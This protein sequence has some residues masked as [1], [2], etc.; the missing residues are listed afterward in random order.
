MRSNPLEEY[1]FFEQL[2]GDTVVHLWGNTFSRDQL[3]E[4][5]RIS[6]PNSEVRGRRV[7][8]PGGLTNVTE[9][10]LSWNGGIT[11]LTIPEDM[12]NMTRLDVRENPL[13]TLSLPVW[14][15]LNNLQI[16]GFPEDRVTFHAGTLKILNEDLSWREGV[17][18][19]KAELS[20]PWVPL[21]VS[22][23]MPLSTIGKSGFFRVKVEKI[24]P[25]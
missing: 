23:P 9:L 12:T 7:T 14:T 11:S 20:A 15:D 8:L 3:G 18:E 21:P 2:N 13:D 10:D 19:F 17:L 25:F 16:V 22:S 4:L 24:D 5:T 6:L 1:S